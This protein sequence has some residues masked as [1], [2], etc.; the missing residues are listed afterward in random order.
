M[1]RK[2]APVWIPALLLFGV[3]FGR[4]VFFVVPQHQQ[5]VITEFGR[6]VRVITEPGL[7]MKMPVT[8]SVVYYDKRLLDH[9]IPPTEI[10]T[11]DKRTLVIDNFAK[12]RI[13]N[14]EQF[15]K[16]ARTEAVAKDRLR[17]VIYS[18]L[19]ID[20]GGHDL[21]E[22]VSTHRSSLMKQVTERAN[23][24]MAELDM[25]V[26][27]VDVR[28]KRADLPPENQLAV[29]RRMT[30]ERKRI[31]KQFRSEGKE[32]AQKIRATTDK[33][34]T[35]LLA[36]AYQQEQKLRGEG[37]SEAIRITAGAFGKDPAFYD[38]IRSL[39]A[40]KRSMV[41]RNTVVISADSPFLKYLK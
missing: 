13:V 22:I 9:D 15:Y 26:E 23:A 5:A 35:I 14:P 19:R 40:Y 25:G 16:R 30:E 11:K 39:E 6:F 33:E 12:W 20:F 36:D 29:F 1:I 31:A 8:Q 34:K 10:V 18:E 21:F 24:K 2:T 32:E 3:I 38:F 27:I 17:D 28:I 4:D 37:D 41:E 7:Q